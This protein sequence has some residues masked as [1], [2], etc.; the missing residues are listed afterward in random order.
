[1]DDLQN[2]QYIAAAL[3]FVWT[4]F[5]RSGL[6]FGGAAL[7][8]PLLLLVVDD[9]LVWLPLIGIHLLFF[10]S[11]TVSSRMQHIDWAYLKKALAIMIIPMLVGVFGLLTLPSEWV[12]VFVYLTTL[13][14]ACCYLFKFQIRS[15]NRWADHVLLMSGAYAAGVSLIG[16]P[17]IVA[18][19]TH[20]VVKEML[21]NTLFVLWFI[22]VVIK[23]SVLWSVD[24]N[25]W[26]WHHLWLLPCAAI[27]H[28]VGLKL[29]D[30]LMAGDATRFKQVIGAVLVLICMVG[31]SAQFENV[32]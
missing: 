19:F 13:F 29:H 4:G 20:H 2:W 23:L 12:V 31:L 9:A 11:I 16:A 17:L 14:Y 1:M 32:L 8:L 22:L 6:G 18:V 27:G 25:F 5:V 21:R 30:H 28:V 10:S 7:G 15:N 26:W 3:I 24:V